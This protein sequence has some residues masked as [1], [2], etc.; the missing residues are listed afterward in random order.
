MLGW[1]GEQRRLKQQ[2]GLERAGEV[3][4]ATFPEAIAHMAQAWMGMTN[5]MLHVSPE[6]WNAQTLDR[7]ILAF[8]GMSTAFSEVEEMFPIVHEKI[9]TS[10]AVS[11]EPE[12]QARTNLFAAI[13]AEAL[14]A[15][16]ED[17]SEVYLTLFPE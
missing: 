16:G 4:R 1:F 8:K 3:I 10:T 7:R 12:E 5:A 15:V 17:R 9:I 11:G 2:Q 6:V 13:L 14:I